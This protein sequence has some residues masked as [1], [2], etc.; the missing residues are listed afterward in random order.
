MNP[1]VGVVGGWRRSTSLPAAKR[2][3]SLVDVMQQQREE[4]RLFPSTLEHPIL[5]P[6]FPREGS[7]I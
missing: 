3:L 5:P 1:E 4:S 7:G 6:T 2:K